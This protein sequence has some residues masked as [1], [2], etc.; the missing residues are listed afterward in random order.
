[1]KQAIDTLRAKLPALEQ[2]WRQLRQWR[3]RRRYRQRWAGADLQAGALHI[4]V[5]DPGKPGEKVRVLECKT[6]PLETPLSA[7]MLAGHAQALDSHPQ[8]WSLLLERDDYR[9]SILPAPA[10]PE[11][12]TIES[13]RWQLAPSLDFDADDA[14][15]GC[16]AL[17]AAAQMTER[18]AELYAVAARGLRVAAH[19]LLFSTAQLPLR[20]IDI[21]ETAQ[22][23]IAALMEREQELLVLVAFMHHEVQITFNWHGELYL[24]RLIA[25][26]SSTDDA[27]ER[28]AA[29]CDRIALQVQ[30]S[31]AAVRNSYPFMQAARIV[32]AGAPPGF[33]DTLAH[34]VDAAVE[35]LQPEDFL[36]LALTPQLRAPEQLMR[37]FH[38]L[39]SALRGREDAA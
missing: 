14:A 10:V 37:Y 25:E 8:Q 9:I 16:M 30:R 4:I 26:S 21:R 33:C 35:A 15:I 22:R 29:L 3:P 24:D 12:E 18:P 2:A 5:L 23:N 13:L 1:M 38:A 11:D 17:P 27:P 6:L 39:G 34:T 32:A 20:A 31:L 28:Q 19:A 36:D 7:E